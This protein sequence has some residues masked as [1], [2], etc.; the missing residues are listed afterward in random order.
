M[1]TRGI[2]LGFDMVDGGGGGADV[3]DTGFY[4]Q[5]VEKI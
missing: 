5:F 1:G 3:V 4:N 2:G